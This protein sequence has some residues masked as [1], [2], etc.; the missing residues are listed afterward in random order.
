ME[1]AASESFSL[2]PWIWFAAAMICIGTIAVFVTKYRPSDGTEN[3]FFPKRRRRRKHRHRHDKSKSKGG[4][5][6]KW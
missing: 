6:L 2:P 5:D 3:P 1:E 4:D